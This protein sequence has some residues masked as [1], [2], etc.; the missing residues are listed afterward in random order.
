MKAPSPAMTTIRQ[1]PLWSRRR[2]PTTLPPHRLLHCSKSA[3]KPAFSRLQGQLSSAKG[4]YLNAQAQVSYVPRF[5]API[6]GITADQSPLRRRDRQPW[7]TAH[8]RQVVHLVTP[9]EGPSR[10]N[11]SPNALKIGDEASVTI[12]GVDVARSPPRSISSA[13]RS[14]PAA[15]LS[16]SGFAS[17]EQYRAPARPA[18]P[19]KS[20]SPRGPCPRPSKSRSPPSSPTANLA[21]GP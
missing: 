8:H 7:H 3:A 2:R 21:P 15:P 11:P 18:L 19:P 5:A 14:I 20:P 4:K 10:P 9:R 1:Q 13:P 12:N 17:K 6:S 16:R